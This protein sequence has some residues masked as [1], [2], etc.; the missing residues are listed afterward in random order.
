LPIF[1]LLFLAL[2][3]FLGA[4]T[5]FFQAY[6]YSEPTAGLLWRAPAAGL[7]MTS[8]FA[9]WSYLDYKNPGGHSTIF[10]FKTPKDEQRFMKF[11][12]VRKGQETLYQAH[13]NSKGF[14]EYRDA[15][16]KSWRRSDTEGITEAIVVEDKDGQKIRFEAQLTDDGKFR[17]A[18]N[19][20]AAHYVEV[21]GERRDM[22][23]EYIGLL[24]RVRTSLIA[25]NL[26]MNALHFVVWFAALWLL[27]RFQ[28]GHAFGF[29]IV[30]WVVMTLTILPMMFKRTEDA[31]LKQATPG[32]V[33][34]VRPGRQAW[35]I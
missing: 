20:S 2:A 34:R 33:A 32:A 26:F 9:F 31:A 12:A 23:D 15:S 24:T 17:M 19:S 4:G 14:Y 8:F 6:I 16:G 21:G 29:A 7:L 28:W 3:V 25:A 10:E 11:W 27:L 35:T 5:L 13:K 30:L 18:P 1:A 22:N